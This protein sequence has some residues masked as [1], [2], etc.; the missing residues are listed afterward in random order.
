MKIIR[1]KRDFIL[2]IISMG[3]GLFVLL[4]D[5]IVK[6]FSLFQTQIWLS[7]A[8]SY[9]RILGGLLAFV[10]L[11]VILRSFVQTAETKKENKEKGRFDYV[12]LISFSAFFLYMLLLKTIGFIP[13]TIW[14]IA[15]ISFMLRARETHLDWHNRKALLKAILISVIYSVILVLAISFVFTTWLSVRLP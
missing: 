8:D 10:S 5:N 12:V 9:L 3:I 7:K 2:G 11:I 13:D 6:G 1:N 15:L 14:L 4:S